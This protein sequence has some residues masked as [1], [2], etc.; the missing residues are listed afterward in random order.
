MF[1]VEVHQVT[2]KV[3]ATGF[4]VS[5]SLCN[6]A[7]TSDRIFVSDLIPNEVAI[8]F[9][10]ANDESVVIHGL[11]LLSNPLEASQG[12]NMLHLVFCCNVI[13]QCGGDNG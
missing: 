8:A 6:H 3:F 7:R 11:N 4:C 12:S 10:T 2:Q 1:A 9:F 13:D 5:C